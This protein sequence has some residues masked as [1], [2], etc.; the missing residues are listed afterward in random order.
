M[1]Y[2][3]YY[4]RL[5]VKKSAAKEDIA[6]AYKQLARK[7]HPDLNKAPDAEK[8][9]KEINEAYEVL[10]DPKKRKQYD[11]L[12][13]NWKH[14]SPYGGFGGGGFGQGGHQRSR[15][16]G[17]GGG[18]ATSAGFSD[19]FDMFFGGAQA[20][21]MNTGAGGFDLRDIFAGGG[22]TASTKRSAHQSPA[23]GRDMEAK[24][25][26]SLED[27]ESGEKK[28]IEL[29][30]ARGKKTLRVKIPT[31]V[32]SGEKIRLAGQGVENAHGSRGDLYLTIEVA[33]HATFRIE[34]DDLV[35]TVEVPAWDAALGGPTTVE[36]LHGP[37]TL[38]LP[39]GVSSGQRLRLKKKGLSRR[40]G[41]TNRGDL[42]VEIMITVPQSLTDQQ[43]DLFEK[44]KQCAFS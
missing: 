17:Q 43:R 11:L 18:R 1:N 33:P 36:T 34:G 7:Y 12:G 20:G 8:K 10:K 31:G 4:K 30:T 24:I 3:D 15:Q 42:L 5:G 16:S 38:K 35:R 29:N 21:N 13:Q 37:V 22:H 23:R 32:R 39:P 44:L 14:G 26:L 9:F 2:V 27:L 28:T 6:K 41:D 40:G 19:F 25:A